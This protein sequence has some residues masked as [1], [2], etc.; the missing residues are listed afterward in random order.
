MESDFFHSKLYFAGL[1]LYVSLVK[2]NDQCLVDLEEFFQ[3]IRTR[4][5]GVSVH[6][7]PVSVFFGHMFVH[8]IVKC[9]LLDLTSRSTTHG[10]P[11]AC[12]NALVRLKWEHLFGFFI[13]WYGPEGMHHIYFEEETFAV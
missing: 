7:D 5:H 13:Q 9:C 1:D 2:R 3:G 12:E 4:G 10:E 11:A 8:S 6:G